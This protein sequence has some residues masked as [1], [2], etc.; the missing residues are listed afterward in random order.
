MRFRAQLLQWTALFAICTGAA[1]AA[2]Q[3]SEAELKAVFLFHFTQFVEW[4]I[5]VFPS[6]D[7]PFVIGILGPDPFNGA[8]EDIVHGEKVGQHP[9]IVRGVSGY[10]AERDCQ[11]LYVTRV[12]ESL[13]D[14]AKLSK[15]PVLTVGESAAFYEAGG[16][17]EFITDHRHVRLRVNLTAARERSLVISAKLLRVAEVSDMTPTIEKFFEREEAARLFPV[18]ADHLVAY[19]RLV[20]CD[21]PERKPS[22]FQRRVL[23]AKTEVSSGAESSPAAS[24]PGRSTPLDSVPD[25]P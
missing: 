20:A 12:A 7:A 1:K 14:P 11:I 4:P 13:L 6:P 19:P 8:L 15:S 22:I 18:R 21:L 24:I 16:L 5:S 3:P 10:Q 23:F 17:I 25:V 2:S 9:L